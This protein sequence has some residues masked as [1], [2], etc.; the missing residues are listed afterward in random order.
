MIASV[1]PTP[2]ARVKDP[3]PLPGEQ[4]PTAL[5][6]Q[7]R[8]VDDEILGR[9]IR[10]HSMPLSDDV[11]YR[12]Q[13]NAFW[14]ALGFDPNLRERADAILDGFLDLAEEALDA[15]DTN[16]AETKRLNAFFLRCEQALD[17]ILKREDSPLAWAGVAA[18]RYNPPARDVIDQLAVAIAQHQRD[19]DNSALWTTFDAVLRDILGPD[20]AKVDIPRG[21]RRRTP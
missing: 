2:W 9:L 3:R 13:W 8:N 11:A 1:G 20:A 18:A 14:S 21:R 10:D 6:R 16:A 12:R 15:G 4:S 7:L 19:L 17:R 5:A